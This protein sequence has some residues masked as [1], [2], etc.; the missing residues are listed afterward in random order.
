[1]QGSKPSQNNG[2]KSPELEELSNA[3]VDITD[4]ESVEP[5][6]PE[7][8]K[9]MT[10]TASRQ[11]L[12]SASSGILNEKHSSHLYHLS[13][14]PLSFEI[15]IVDVSGLVRHLLDCNNDLS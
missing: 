4:S 1:M 7:P 6:P 15:E 5:A 14:S 3:A 8:R 10:V 9:S 13:I 12:G 2:N 11:L